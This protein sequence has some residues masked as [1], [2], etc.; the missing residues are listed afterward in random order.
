METF[1]CYY[2]LSLTAGIFITQQELIHQGIEVKQLDRE[3]T[4]E[5]MEKVD[6][7]CALFYITVEFFQIDSRVCA[8]FQIF[9]PIIHAGHWSLVVLSTA[10][11]ETYILD[12][13]PRYSGVAKDVLTQLQKYLN[14]KHS[15]DM[16]DYTEH[17]PPVQPQKNK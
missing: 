14:N 6:L 12:S 8:F 3:L 10:K 15:F 5:V 7:V 11:Q 13:Y 2:Y 4:A 1:L 16:S 17:V 9:I